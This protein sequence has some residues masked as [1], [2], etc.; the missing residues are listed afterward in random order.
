MWKIIKSSLEQVKIQKESFTLGIKWQFKIEFA[1]L[2][3][4]NIIDL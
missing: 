3:D 1:I 2:S 4:Y